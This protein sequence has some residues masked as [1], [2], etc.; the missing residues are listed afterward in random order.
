[1]TAI[2]DMNFSSL[3]TTYKIYTQ[4]AVVIDFAALVVSPTTLTPACSYTLAKSY[5]YANGSTMTGGLGYDTSIF[6]GLTDG[7]LTVSTTNTAKTGTYK[8]NVTQT[9]IDNV[10]YTFNTSAWCSSNSCPSAN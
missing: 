1:M 9:A 3:A 5:S 4:Q 6:S 8:I 2:S 7:K 10:S